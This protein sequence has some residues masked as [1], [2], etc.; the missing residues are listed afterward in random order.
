MSILKFLVCLLCLFSFRTVSSDFGSI[1]VNYG[2]VANDLP[3]PPQVV[4]LLQSN[5]I[6]RVK[7]FDANPS[8]IS[9]FADTNI[10]VTIAMPNQLLSA[11][12][13]INFTNRWLQARIVPFYP[14][15][16]TEAIA[17]GNEVFMDPQN[18]PY[19]VPAMKTCLLYC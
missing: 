7:I 11:A 2:R 16:M 12:A 8:I 19:L 3:D 17:I 15:T 4:E 13:N 1:G 10:K 9:A 14:R 6:S 18:T 5:G